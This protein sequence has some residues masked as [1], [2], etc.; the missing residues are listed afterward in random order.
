MSDESPSQPDGTRYERVQQWKT[1]GLGRPEMLKKLKADGL[2][3]ESALVLINSVI[4]AMPSDLPTAQL[5]PGRNALAP[6]VFTLSDIGLTGPSHVVGMYWIGFGAAILLA[7]GLGAL[8]SA[9]G[10]VELPD[11][12]GYYAARL[13]GFAAMVCVSWGVFRYT[14]GVS[15]RRR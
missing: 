11:D 13:G 15:I 4:G 1:Q 3:D 5:S 10:L 14:Q 2:D 8:M 12:V 9:T 7:L 6:S